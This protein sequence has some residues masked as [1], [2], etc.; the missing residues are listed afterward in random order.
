MAAAIL[1]DAGLD[2]IVLCGFSMGA[3]LCVELYPRLVAR[4]GAVR[5]VFIAGRAPPVLG[6]SSTG[7]EGDVQGSVMVGPEVPRPSASFRRRPHAAPMQGVGL[8]GVGGALP[9]PPG[10][11]PRGSPSPSPS[12]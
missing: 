6:G 11:R 7:E 12:P 1:R 4:G 2:P 5:Q 9:P 10:R 3:L 8:G